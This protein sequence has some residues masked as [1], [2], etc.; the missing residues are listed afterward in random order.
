MKPDLHA[1]R[2]CFMITPTDA[3][4]YLFIYF[5][6]LTTSHDALGDKTQ[7]KDITSLISSNTD[8]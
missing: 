7:D 5:S 2:S 6:H 4:C 1:V 3:L 8:K